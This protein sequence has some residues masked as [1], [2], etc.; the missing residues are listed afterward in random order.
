MG[1]SKDFLYLETGTLPIRWII[2]QRRINYLKH[3]LSR[4]ENELIRKVFM[5]QKEKPNHGDFIKLVES[6]LR[7]FELSYDEVA[8]DTMS[9][10]QLKKELRKRAEQLGFNELI[11]NT[12]TSSK[13]KILKYNH[14]RMQDYLKSELFSPNEVSILVALRSKCLKGIKGNFKN[15][16]QMC[17]H[18]PLQC[19]KET[20]ALDTQDHLLECSALGG[21]TADMEFIHASPVEQSFLTKEVSRLI[22]KRE[23]MLESRDPSDCCRLPGATWTSAP[24]GEQQL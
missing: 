7:L 6:D 4:S 11:K 17:Q 16:H 8:S 15:M 12:T 14:L 22:K 18:C 24:S 3:I 9:K 5:A 2:P 19:S 21:S 10:S 1:T 13:T 23:Q 20:P